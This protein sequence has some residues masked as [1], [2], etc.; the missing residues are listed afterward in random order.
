MP[1]LNQTLRST[2]PVGYEAA[3]QS[4][5]TPPINS[6]QDVRTVGA[7]PY[8]RTTLPPMNVGPDTLRQFNE[9]GKTPT[10]RVI[11]LPVSTAVGGGNVTN[12]TTVIQQGSSGGG[13]SS[14]PKLVSASVN[15]NSPTLLPGQTYQQ[16]VQ[17]AKSFQLLQVTSSQPVEIRIYADSLTQAAD[18]VRITD[19]AVPFEIVAGLITD[20]VFDTTPFQWNWQNRMGANADASQSTNIYVTVINPSQVAGALPATTAITFL[21]LES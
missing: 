3:E 6:V 11:P 15:V 14:T 2:S 21:P 7:N 13:G 9:N 5:T 10:R 20:V 8:I 18:L 12:N 4:P 17:M 16:T 1:P 19:H